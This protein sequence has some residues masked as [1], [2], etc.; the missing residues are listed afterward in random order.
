MERKRYL[1]D[2]TNEQWIAIEKYFYVGKYGNRRKYPIRE[3]VDAIF[4]FIKTG[5]QW[6]F[7][8]HD[9]PPFEAVRSFFRRCK[10]RGTWMLVMDALVKKTVLKMEKIPNRRTV[11]LTHKP[12]KL[13]TN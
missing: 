6:R 10:E 11:L 9:F 3:L 8:P 12:Q 2:I 7:L 13:C 4:Y 1:S 5:C